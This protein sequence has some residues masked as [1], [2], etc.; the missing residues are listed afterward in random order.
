MSLK[1][2]LSFVGV[3]LDDFMA[4]WRREAEAALGF[5]KN[6]GGLELFKVLAQREVHL[7]FFL[8][9]FAC[10]LRRGVS[11]CL[12]FSFLMCSYLFPV[13]INSDINKHLNQ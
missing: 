2:S 13:F 8:V 12:P 7:Y 4:T 10:Y 9:V 3:K 1:V 5:S 6:F 11:V